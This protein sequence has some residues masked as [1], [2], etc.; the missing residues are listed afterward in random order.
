MSELTLHLPPDLSKKL[1]AIAATQA[2][3]PESLVLDVL[4]HYAEESDLDELAL[5][6]TSA[7]LKAILEDLESD[8]DQAEKDNWLNAF[9]KA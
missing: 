6:R 3:D 8:L 7:D 9:S 1:R 2:K 4:E 5:L